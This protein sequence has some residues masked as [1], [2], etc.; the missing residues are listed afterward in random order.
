MHKKCGTPNY[1]DLNEAIKCQHYCLSKKGDDENPLMLL[2]PTMSGYI[3]AHY[4]LFEYTD[5]K[6]NMQTFFNLQDSNQP[7]L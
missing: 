5:R 6:D 7:E 1:P 3:S 2:V 4:R